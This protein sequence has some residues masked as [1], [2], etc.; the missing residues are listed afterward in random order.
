MFA[1]GLAFPK[2]VILALAKKKELKFFKH[3]L[4]KPKFGNLLLNKLGL[5]T[6]Y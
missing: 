4:I 5:V 6:T 1:G 3:N 2:S